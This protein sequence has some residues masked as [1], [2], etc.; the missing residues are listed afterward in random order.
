MKARNLSWAIKLGMCVAA[1]AI[2]YAIT[3]ALIAQRKPPPQ[4][5]IEERTVRVEVQVARFQKTQT[6]ITGYGEVR[7]RD[8]YNI[9]AGISGKVVEIHPRLEAGEIIRAGE[10]LFKIE[11]IDYQARVDET[12]AAVVQFTNSVKRLQIQFAN[13]RERLKTFE[14]SRDLAK[15]DFERS[16]NLFS[17]D[18]IESQSLVDS[19]ELAYNN[20]RDQYALLEQS[21]ELYPLRIV[22]AQSN[23]VSANATLNR[24]EAD[25]ERT[26]IRTVV[27]VRVKD[28]SLELYQFL[29]PGERVLTLADDSVLEISVPINSREARKW[30]R[31]D[32]K[33]SADER[34]WF[35][36]LTR[37]PVEV[38][39]TEA[40]D[41]HRWTGTLHRVERF[42]QQ[43][44]TLTVVVR[45]AGTDA[46]APRNGGLPLVEGMFCK[47]DIPGR[48]VTDV[49]KL[50]SEAV[51]FDREATGFRTVYVAMRDIETGKVRLKSKLVKESH[52]EGD[53]VFVSAAVGADTGGASTLEPGDLVITTRLINPLEGI[54]LELE[55][56]LPVDTD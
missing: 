53:Y 34:A 39:W 2:G 7:A 48:T 47:I 19:K 49:V 42:D 37:T 33:K 24:A 6:N 25:L 3:I 38:A 16:S 18:N 54:L 56:P 10:V 44:R 8:I 45:I 43:T 35:N 41:E 31:F 26:V 52:I 9:S 13:D 17:R 1:I 51:T 36:E 4:A 46:L 40:M 22:E 23:L 12:T 55:D 11:A 27:D 5:A 14:R 32:E 50:P 21:L 30:L 28:V 20:S 15:A 29:M